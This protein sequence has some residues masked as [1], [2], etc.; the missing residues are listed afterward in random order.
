MSLWL[1]VFLPPD[2]YL[3]AGSLSV[4][5]RQVRLPCW[6]SSRQAGGRPGTHPPVDGIGVVPGY[7]Y[8]LAIFLRPERMVIIGI[9]GAVRQSTEEGAEAPLIPSGIENQPDAQHGGSHT[10]QNAAGQKRFPRRRQSPGPL[11]LHTRSYMAPTL[12]G[13]SY[14]ML[15]ILSKLPENLYLCIL[16]CPAFGCTDLF[17][18][19]Y[20]CH[21]NSF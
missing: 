7:P 3:K 14:H 11:G 2:P 10:R 13:A 21:T 4:V 5:Q 20:S 9:N 6:K 19:V 17:I 8:R 12:F 15:G 18:D 16:S 1:A